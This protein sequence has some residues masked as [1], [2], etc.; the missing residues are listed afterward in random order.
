MLVAANRALLVQWID[1]KK[2]VCGTH[3]SQLLPTGDKVT[4]DL[5][6]QFEKVLYEEFEARKAKL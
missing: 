3:F 6:T 5:R 4:N 1:R 2:G